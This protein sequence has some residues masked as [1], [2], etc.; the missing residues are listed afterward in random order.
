MINLT[1]ILGTDSL[2]ASRLTLNDNFKLIQDHL[3]SSESILNTQTGTLNLP[4]KAAAGSLEIR[5]NSQLEPLV[6]EMNSTSILL[7]KPV[8]VNKVLN[9]N[10]SIKENI[11]KISSNSIGEF[12]QLDNSISNNIELNISVDSS[13]KKYRIS[14]LAPGNKLTIVNTG[15]NIALI[16]GLIGVSHV[17]LLTYGTLEVIQTSIGTVLSSVNNKATIVE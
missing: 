6:A 11:H 7:H 5:N 3:N 16:S 10:G 8:S 4:G 14:D 2:S 12:T 1:N 17:K 9:V 15:T 13:E